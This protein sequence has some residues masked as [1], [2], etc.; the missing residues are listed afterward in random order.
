MPD[1]V[2]KAVGMLKSTTFT[3]PGA[4]EVDLR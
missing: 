2:Y 3:L 4:T 1:G